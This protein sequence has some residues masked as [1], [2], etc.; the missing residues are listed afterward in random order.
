MILDGLRHRLIA[1]ELVAE[2]ITAFL[3]KMNRQRREDGAAQAAEERELATVTRKI[4]GLLDAIEDG[5]RGPDVQDR[6]DQLCARRDALR[7]AISERVATPVRLHPNLA[8]VYAEKVEH[9]H[10][11]LQD[12]GI[13]DEAVPILRTL[14]EKIIVQPGPDGLEVEIVGDI[15]RMVE[16]GMSGGT[17]AKAALGERAACSVKVVAGVGF[18]PT[19]FR[20]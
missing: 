13:R 11:A 9:L 17:N 12:P 5:L 2:F 15:A 20:L 10:E 7:L 1:P 4:A 19:T 8:Q 14:I 16:L 3:E 18:E 6:L